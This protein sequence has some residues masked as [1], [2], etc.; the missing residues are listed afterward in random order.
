MIN[1]ADDCLA[2]ASACSEKARGSVAQEERVDAPE[3]A[4]Q[5]GGRMEIGVRPEFLRLRNEA[6][7]GTLA[8]KIASVRDLGNFKIVGVRLGEHLL[9]VKVAEDQDLPAE[10][11][12]LGF[13]AEMTRLYANGVLVG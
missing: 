12:H 10:Q 6:G 13:T 4:R 11:A 1:R 9:N 3:R 8:V 5:R 2:R 7:D